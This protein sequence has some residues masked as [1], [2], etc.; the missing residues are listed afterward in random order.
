MALGFIDM[1]KGIDGL[2]MLVRNVLQQDPFTGHLFVF[3][4]RTR[5]NL[6]KIF[7][8]MTPASAFYQTARG[9]GQRTAPDRAKPNSETEAKKAS[10]ATA[11]ELY[12]NAQEVEELRIALATNDTKLPEAQR[13]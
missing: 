2:A 8:A 1:R 6:I 4:S 5:A 11:A 9:R 3:R 10:E 7:T 12:A 13:T